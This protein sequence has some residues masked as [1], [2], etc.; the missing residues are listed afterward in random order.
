MHS[1]QTM[2]ATNR[3][4]LGARPGE[5]AAAA[6]DPRGWLKRQLEDSAASRPTAP[7]LRSADAAL[8]EFIA[9][10]EQREAELKAGRPGTGSPRSEA[11]R[12]IE[13]RTAFA[14]TTGHGF[15][16]RLVRFWSNHFTVSTTKPQVAVV[17]GAFEREAI[18]PHVTGRFADLLIAAQT[19]QA[20]LLYLDNALS[21]GPRSPA[22]RR[23]GRGLNENQAR[24]VLELHTVGVDGG[25][26]QKDVIELAKAMTGWSVSGPRDSAPDGETWFDG[27][28]HEPG[29][30][31]VLGKRHADSG[32]RQ[33]LDI[34]AD[35]AGRPQTARFVATKLARHFIADE[36][37]VAAVA[38]LER[39]FVDSG[40]HLKVVCAA[41]VEV[42]EAWLPEQRKFKSP[43]EFFVSALR[44]LGA[45]S[46]RH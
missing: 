32:S 4:G 22:G 35:L 14:L 1:Q 3:F 39:A 25:Y 5:A 31:T 8:R 2:I 28:R 45:D 18:R 37:P 7:G 17:A 36:P 27:R 43:D 34:L 26:G 16:E 42:E 33:A 20:M 41:L 30:R 46:I 12:E 19:H 44:G 21:V 6:S 11:A 9:W 24:E 10:R 29:T 13:A 38:R 23:S 15:R 40:G